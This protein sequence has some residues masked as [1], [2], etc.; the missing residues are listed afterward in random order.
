MG[1]EFMP[2]IHRIK[3]WLYVFLGFI[4][5]R[6]C[7]GCK[8]KRTYLCEECLMSLPAAICE[9]SDIIA[10]YD[11]NHPTV[12]RIIW[13]IKYHGVREL[14]ELMGVLLYERIIEELVDRNIFFRNEKPHLVIPIPLYPRRERARGYNQAEL[15][16]R[17]LA[18]AN[19]EIFELKTDI[20]RRIK[21]TTSQV[22]LK[23]RKTR[24]E[25]IKGAFQAAKS[26]QV[27]NR[28]ILLVDDVMTTGA[29]VA[30]AKNVLLSAGARE[31]IVLAV[32]HGN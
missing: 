13:L 26:E 31:V 17:A 9:G 30:E 14:A 7:L 12:R 1:R 23:N 5:P 3:E 27:R 2:L 19:K 20:I 16:A 28:D 24:I 6:Q 15:I 11:Y 32:A 10:L 21:D 4:F 25:N 18:G 8:R 22:T 29:T